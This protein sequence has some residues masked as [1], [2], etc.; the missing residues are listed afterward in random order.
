MYEA[1]YGFREK[2]FSAL[3][4]PDFLYL[5]KKHEMAL[6]YLEYGLSSQSGFMVLTGEVGAGKTTL[7]NYLLRNLGSKSARVALIFQTNLQPLELLE[8]I[9]SEWDL[10]YAGK[11][12]TQ[13]YELL[14]S[15]LLENYEQQ[16]PVILILDEA[17][18]L[19]FETLE[20]VRMISNLND[21]K[22]PLLH[23]IFSGQPNLKDKLN[24]PRLTQL[25][26]R[27]T[28]H[29]HLEPLEIDETTIYIQHRLKSAGSADLNIFSPQAVQAVFENSNGIPRVVNLIC[30][31]ALV[32]GFAEQQRIIS[33]N[34]IEMVLQDRRKMGL[35]VGMQEM[36]ADTGEVSG[37]RLEHVERKLL[38]LNDNVYEIALIIRKLI[39]SKDALNRTRDHI[40]VLEKR[41]KALED[42]P[43]MAAYQEMFY[44]ILQ[45]L[46]N[47]KEEHK[48]EQ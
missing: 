15:Y 4:D 37:S 27:V 42:K 38:E 21:E 25:R 23:I 39:K 6:T 33:R 9:L 28:V 12:R 1:F 36:L 22:V 16:Q 31:L 32:Y 46:D 17:Q 35:G 5:S 20:E 43:G 24:N 48:G 2:P 3:P 26:Q 18:N 44:N 45:E 8:A 19:P 30:D 14:S 29:Y 40:S 7:L 34:I 10:P 11:S 47:A 41:V 13:M